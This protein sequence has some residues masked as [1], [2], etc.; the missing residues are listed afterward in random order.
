[1][2][3]DLNSPAAILEEALAE[4]W[5]TV[6]GCSRVAAND[7]FFELGGTS[8]HAIRLHQHIR[9]RLKLD[10]TVLA[11]FQ[12][13]TVRRFVAALLRG[14]AGPSEE[15]VTHVPTQ[16]ENGQARLF[17]GQGD[18]RPFPL[19][20]VEARVAKQVEA[21]QTLAASRRPLYKTQIKKL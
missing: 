10:C 4:S 21:I 19:S 2:S 18:P 8:L 17:S 5:R 7:N 16:T 9:E 1:M 3:I 20:T 14:G 11:I 12:Y 6:L 15:K 13:P